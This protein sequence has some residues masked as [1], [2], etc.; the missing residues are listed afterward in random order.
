MMYDIKSVTDDTYQEL[1]IKL[2]GDYSSAIYTSLQRPNDSVSGNPTDSK[3]Q[4]ML[5]LMFSFSML[6]LEQ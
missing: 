5:R 1:G 3:N 4:I 2:E 6:Y